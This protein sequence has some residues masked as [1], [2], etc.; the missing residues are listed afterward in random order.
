MVDDEPTTYEEASCEKDWKRAMKSEL[1]SIER[2]N[3][4][5]LAKL[6]PNLKEIGLRWVSNLK[7]MQLEK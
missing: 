1:E 4:W 2:N 5:S 7:G 3:T 6:P